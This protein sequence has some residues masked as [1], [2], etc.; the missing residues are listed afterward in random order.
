MHCAEK[1]LYFYKTAPKFKI[2]EKFCILFNVF[3]MC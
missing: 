1:N 3:K 2:I